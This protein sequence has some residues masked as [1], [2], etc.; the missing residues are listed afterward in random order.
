MKDWEPGAQRLGRRVREL[1]LAR[2]LLQQHLADAAGLHRTYIADIE[3][4][5]RNP[6]LWT[7]ERLARGLG[8]DLQDLFSQPRR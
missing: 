3:R 6:S 2:K 1:R 8:C 5:K 4:G 7:I